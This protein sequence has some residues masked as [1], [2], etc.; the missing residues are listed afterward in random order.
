MVMDEVLDEFRNIPDHIMYI[1]ALLHLI[2]FSTDEHLGLPWSSCFIVLVCVFVFCCFVVFFSI[3]TNSNEKL[4]KSELIYMY[5]SL[6]PLKC[7]LYHGLSLN[8]LIWF[9]KY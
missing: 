7:C 6:R 3:W 4:R 9:R 2:L 5:V 8:L 1:L